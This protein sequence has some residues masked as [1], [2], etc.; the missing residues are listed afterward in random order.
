MTDVLAILVV[1]ASVTVIAGALLRL[2][3]RVRRRG[4]GVDVLGPFEEMWHPAAHRSR[5]EV[6]VQEERVAPMPTPDD[7]VPPHRSTTGR[8]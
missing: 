4:V 6:R 3:A 8:Q 2:G 5:Q 7:L 1:V